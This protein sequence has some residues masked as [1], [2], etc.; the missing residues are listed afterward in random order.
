MIA[1]DG[2]AGSGK[3]TLAKALAARLGLRYLD[4]G[5]M[6]RAVTLAATRRGIAAGDDERLAALVGA[7]EIHLEAAPD[8]LRV[9]LDGEDVSA[10]IRTEEISRA[11]APYASRPVVRRAMVVLQRVQRDRGGLVA[12]GRDIGTV[13]FPDADWKFYLDADPAERARRRLRDVGGDLEAVKRDIEAR[14]SVD[15]GREHSPLT[16]APDAV[17]IDTTAM[18]IDDVLE[19]MMDRIHGR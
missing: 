15:I 8:G 6:Y 2:P 18:T 10:A 1:I 5:A 3:S 19:T 14:D 12:E 17:R 13:V 11:V 16:E 4:T 9:T 7:I